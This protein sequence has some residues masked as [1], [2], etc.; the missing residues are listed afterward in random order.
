MA[1]RGMKLGADELYSL[2]AT[3]G[4]RGSRAGFSSNDVRAGQRG[5]TSDSTSAI[6]SLV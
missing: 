5:V 4:L 6:L 2:T 1:G 3:N